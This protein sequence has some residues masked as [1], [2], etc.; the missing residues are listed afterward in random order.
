MF[1]CLK[2]QMTAF[3]QGYTDLFGKRMLT[4]EKD[5][6]GTE[7]MW[8]SYGYII[9]YSVHMC[10]FMHTHTH[11]HTRLGHFRSTYFSYFNNTDSQ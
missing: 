6:D 11:T 4:S 8:L 3:N 2:M 1:G 5:I 7:R 9:V 10:A